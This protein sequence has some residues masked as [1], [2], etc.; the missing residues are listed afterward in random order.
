V[1]TLDDAALWGRRVADERY[2]LVILA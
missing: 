2:M 1:R